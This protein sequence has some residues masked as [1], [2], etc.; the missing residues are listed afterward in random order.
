[1]TL[2]EDFEY[3]DF[4]NFKPVDYPR[5]MSWKK[6]TGDV[7]RVAIGED[8]LTKQNTD[9]EKNSVTLEAGWI[10]VVHKMDFKLERS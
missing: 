4:H 2:N 10:V 9:E 5:K 7:G 3:I 6:R 8:V 1:E